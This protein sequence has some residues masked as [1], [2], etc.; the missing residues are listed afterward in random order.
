MVV[1]L[2]FGKEGKDLGGKTMDRGDSKDGNESRGCHKNEGLQ[3][4][5]ILVLE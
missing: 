1:E 5:L 2:L 3:G 4:G